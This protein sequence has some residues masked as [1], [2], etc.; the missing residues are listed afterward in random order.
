ME[1]FFFESLLNASA[2]FFLILDA[3]LFANLLEIQSSVDATFDMINKDDSLGLKLSSM[4]LE[5]KI[6]LSCLTQ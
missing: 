6:I 5:E 3:R 2:G 4:I 1:S